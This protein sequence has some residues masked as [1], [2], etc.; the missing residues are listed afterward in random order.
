MDSLLWWIILV[1]LIVLI[2]VL[3]LYF[4]YT[5]F[6]DNSIGQG[7]IPISA[8]SQTKHKLNKYRFQKTD[9]EDLTSIEAKYPVT[10]RKISLIDQVEAERYTAKLV[11]PNQG[12]RGTITGNKRRPSLLTDIHESGADFG[13]AYSLE[14]L[15]TEMELDKIDGRDSV[16]ADSFSSRKFSVVTEGTTIISVNNIQ[17]RQTLQ[18]LE[19]QIYASL[20]IAII[21]FKR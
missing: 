8:T 20:I 1:C 4:V 12:R 21:F 15:L 19:I 9:V 3:S 11:T 10:T 16:S 14:N 5:V 18:C 13:S 7:A 6:S 2:T 17:A